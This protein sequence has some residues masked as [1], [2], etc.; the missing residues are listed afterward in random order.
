[1]TQTGMNSSLPGPY[2]VSHGASDAPL[3][4]CLHGIG[5]NADAFEPQHPLAERTGR[6]LVAWD[7]PGYRNSPDPAAAPG[8]EGWA[9]MAADLIRSELAKSGSATPGPAKTVEV[10]GVSWGGVIAT[11]LYLRHP[12]LVSALILADSSSGA[13]GR[14]ETAEVM[15][16]RAEGLVSL[17]SE[18]FASSRTKVLLSDA[19]PD[20][21]RSNVAEMMIETLR[22]PSYQWACDSMADTYHS[23]ELH[24]IQ[25]PTLVLVGE[26]DQVTP[27]KA[28]QKL[29]EAIPNARLQTIANAGHLANQE[30]PEA[31]NNA[32]AEFLTSAS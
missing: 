7:A 1:M 29:A 26:H 30:Q 18:E 28:S 21:L 17:G 2:V 13:G 12:E 14:P 16:S 6:R 23:P 11:S 15:R 8:I 19:A 27:P 22:M 10:L 3:L 5:S 24:R 32:V 20:A 25:V 4:L 9:D 31:F